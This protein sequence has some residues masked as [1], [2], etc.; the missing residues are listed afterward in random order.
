MGT[1]GRISA[2]GRAR[3]PRQRTS[4][5]ETRRRRQARAFNASYRQAQISLFAREAEEGV[6][7]DEAEDGAPSGNAA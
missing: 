5:E 6:R 3:G 7:R 2:S 1:K 4:A